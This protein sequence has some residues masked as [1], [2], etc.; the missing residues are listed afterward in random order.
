M[1][2]EI[3]SGLW[4]GDVNDSLNINFIKDNM[5]KILINCTTTYGFIDKVETKKLRIPITYNLS[6][7]KDQLFI[8]NNKEKILNYIFKN[9][10]ENNILIFCYDGLNIS[11]LIVSLFLIKYGGISKD[12]VRNVLRSKNKN[13]CLDIDLSK[14]N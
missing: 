12:D 14:F 7:E 1:P 10:E 5:I 9:L 6:P 4:I 3:L 11:P 8:I 13:I 2:T